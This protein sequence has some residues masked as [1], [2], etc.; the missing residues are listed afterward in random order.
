MIPIPDDEDE[1]L[2]EVLEVSKHEAEFQRRAG[3]HYEHGGGSGGGGVRGFFRRATSQRE[4]PKDFDAAR[5]KAPVQ[6]RIDTD[7]WTNKGKSTKE[8]IGRIWSKWFQVSGILSRNVDNPYFISTAKQTQSELDDESPD[9]DAP[10]PS[11]MVIAIAD[12]RD[13]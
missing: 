7:P 6:T 4:R 11:A 1:E 5:A 9:T 3:E 10:I 2:Q 8:A 13:L 12:H